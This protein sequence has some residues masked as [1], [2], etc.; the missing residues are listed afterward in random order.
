MDIVVAG[1]SGYLGQA[2]VRSLTA[3]GHQVRVLTRRPRHAGD[4]QWPASDA[5]PLPDA[6]GA[7]GAV[8]NL[9]GEPLDRRWTPA[10]KALIR[11]SR[12]RTTRRLVGAITAAPRPPVL[13]N[14]SAVGFYGAHGDEVITERDPPASDFLARVVADWEA[15]ALEASRV[16]RVVLLR[17][18]IVLSREGGALPKLE[19]PFRFFVGGRVGSGRQYVSWI[20]RDD[21]IAMTAWAIESS[22]VAGPLNAT[23]PNPVTNADLARAL[24][25]A[26][27]RPSFF[28]APAFAVRLLLGEMA[29]AAVLTGQRVVPARAQALGFRFAY[30]DIDA[31]LAAIYT[32]A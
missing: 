9:A 14:S 13:V 7:A 20:H 16:T 30:P 19:R 31:A 32:G 17:S 5:E 2:L 29:D 6:V 1:G 8:V 24:G 18:G 10:R 11:D 12:V 15:A 26:M 28:P 23:A 21:W 22:A 25:A 3:N 27:H 4:I